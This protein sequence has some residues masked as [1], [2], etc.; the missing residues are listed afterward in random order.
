MRSVRVQ[1]ALQEPVAVGDGLITNQNVR[2]SLDYIPGGVL[3][4]A[5]AQ[6]LLEAA[7]KHST[8]GRAIANPNLSAELAEGQFQLL[9]R[10]RFSHLY[11]S[12]HSALPAPATMLRCR[13]DSTH[14]YDTLAALIGRRS[15][16]MQCPACGGRLERDRGYL[17]RA[18]DGW[19]A[20]FTPPKQQYRRLGISRLTGAVQSGTFFYNVEAIQPVYATPHQESLSRVVFSGTLTFL[21]DADY[22][23]FR[24]LL[25]CALPSPEPER[26]EL[27]IGS[28][29]ARGFGRVQMSLHAT[30]PEPAPA[31]RLR[32]FREWLGEP[33]FTLMAH[34]QII[35]F[36]RGRPADT[37]TPEVL[38]A[39]LP[40]LPS[41]VQ[42][43]PEAT[44]VEREG[45]GGWS[46][47]WGLHKPT[48]TAFA[49]GSV[50]TY[51]YDPSQQD[52]LAQWLSV[53]LDRGIGERT[54]EGYGQFVVCGDVHRVHAYPTAGGTYA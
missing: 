49:R 26:W 17:Y 4:G 34:S 47:A 43:I 54:M 15:W 48:Y 52:E 24:E 10:V 22:E 51:S 28:A 53:L 38:N 44:R 31:E 1:L 33:V 9:Q 41:S 29:R 46:Q 2:L 7:H 16:E 35:A 30:E 39:Y 42:W 27:R 13:E 5:L 11:S 21:D 6:S 37:L 19:R 18:E 45:V 14:R 20:A 40:G 50:F 25:R 12:P 3:R 8:S 36:H 23:P 32:Q